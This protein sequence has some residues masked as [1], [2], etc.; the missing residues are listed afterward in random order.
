ML[1]AC[2]FLRAEKG[3]RKKMRKREKKKN[4]V[5]CVLQ[6]TYLNIDGAPITSCSHTHP[7]HSQESRLLT[8]SISL[9]VHNGVHTSRVDSLTKFENSM[10]DSLSLGV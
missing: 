1:A 4:Q 5:G 7:S 2:P 8:S 9:G 3:R 6:G 10:Y